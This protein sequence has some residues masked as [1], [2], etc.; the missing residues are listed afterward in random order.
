MARNGEQRA[1]YLLKASN[2]RRANHAV[3]AGNPNTLTLQSCRR[4]LMMRDLY[5]SLGGR[6]LS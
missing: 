5:R 1:V 3:V 2:Q 4:R 6:K